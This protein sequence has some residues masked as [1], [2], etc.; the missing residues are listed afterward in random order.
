VTAP[1]G[2]LDVYLPTPP[3]VDQAEIDRLPGRRHGSRETVWLIV[4]VLMAL[5]MA[6]LFPV[7]IP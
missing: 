2:D 4:A 6:W 3:T 7:V 1:G 5:L